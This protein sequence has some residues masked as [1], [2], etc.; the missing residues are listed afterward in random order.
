MPDGYYC[1]WVTS[2][3]VCCLYGLY[4][5]L[6][7]E[8]RKCFEA[9]KGTGIPGPPIDSLINGNADAFWKPTQIESLRRWHEEYGDVFGFFLGTVPVAVI[10]DVNMIKQILNKDFKNFS[11]RGHVLH[12]YE[13]QPLVCDTIAVASGRAWKEARTCMQQFFSPSK[14][15]AVMPSLWDCQNELID[16]LNT[17]ANIGAEVNISMLCERFTFDVI[18][19]AAFGI[20]TGVQKNP[21]NPLFQTALTV[22]PNFMNEFAYRTCQNLYS[23]PWLLRSLVKV[24]TKLFSDPVTEMRNKAKAVIEFRRRNP[25]VNLPDLAQI[26]IDDALSRRYAGSK[27]NRSKSEERAPLSPAEMEILA[28]HSMSI[29]VGGYDTTRLVL[30][31]WFYLMGKHPDIQEKM[32]KEALDAYE[33]EGDHLSVEALGK[34]SY[35]NQ[36]ISETLRMY[37]PTI[38]FTTRCAEKDYQCGQYLIKKGI[39]VLIPVY[40]LHHDPL[41]WV[42]PETFDPDRFSPKNKHLINSVAYQPFGLGPRMCLGYRLALLELASVTTQV[43]RHFRITLGPS[44]RPDLELHTY[45]LQ[46]VPKYDVWIKLCPFKKKK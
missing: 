38:T 8:R 4:R 42:D 7:R 29:F 41:W 43:L 39:S 1:V 25:Q 21:D 11:A 40:Q 33:S 36:V 16:V 28:G 37:P 45:S 34:L 19:K 14:L 35:T 26:L 15:K 27:M 31:S 30:T 44:Q 46:A 2:F 12:L 10:K 17:C 24:L 6:L 3:V 5:W 32:R 23:W 9:F 22:L 18:S 13:L 20:D